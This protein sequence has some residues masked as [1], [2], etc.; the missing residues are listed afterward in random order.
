MYPIWWNHKRKYL[1]RKP[2]ATEEE[3][4]V[5]AKTGERAFNF[6]EGFPENLKPL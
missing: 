4:F 2:D 6:I 1:L 5:A 3:N